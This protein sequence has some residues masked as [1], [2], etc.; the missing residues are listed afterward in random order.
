MG[1]FGWFWGR[2]IG[3]KGALDFGGFWGQ[4]GVWA[5]GLG[6]S[7]GFGFQRQRD[8]GLGFGGLGLWGLGAPGL[9]VSATDILARSVGVPCF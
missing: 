1:A 4:R 6:L 8:K 3:A 7:L 2:G 9:A 5:E